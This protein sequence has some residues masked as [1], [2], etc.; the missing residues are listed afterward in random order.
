M[1]KGPRELR[2]FQL[3]SR[4]QLEL[5]AINKYEIL[6]LLSPPRAQYL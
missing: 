3:R 2:G 4:D 5:E 1:V 6:R